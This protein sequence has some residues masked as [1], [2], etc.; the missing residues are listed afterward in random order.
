MDARQRLSLVNGRGLDRGSGA[1][2][3]EEIF[4][5]VVAVMGA[6]GSLGVVLDGEDWQCPVPESFVCAVVEVLM[7]DFQS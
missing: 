6:R 1:H 3:G 5:E 7:G 4:E 2:H